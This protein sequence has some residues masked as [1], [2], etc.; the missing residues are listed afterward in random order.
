MGRIVVIG[1]G[2]TGLCGALMLAR[3]GHD[4]PRAGA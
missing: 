3:D 1:G 4:G 2:I